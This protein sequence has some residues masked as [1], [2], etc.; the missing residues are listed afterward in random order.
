MWG[1]RGEASVAPRLGYM[2]I[3]RRK[4]TVVLPG[5]LKDVVLDSRCNK[6]Q[7]GACEKQLLLSVN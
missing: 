2:H 1:P 4:H 7:H 6:L 5:L 3:M